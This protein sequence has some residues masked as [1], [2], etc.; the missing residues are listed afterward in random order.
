MPATVN[1][2]VLRLL[3][4]EAPL[5]FSHYFERMM[6]LP[7]VWKADT[8]PGWEGASQVILTAVAEW[9]SQEIRAVQAP[10][11]SGVWMW[12]LPHTQAQNSHRHPTGARWAW[13]KTGCRFSFSAE[14]L[15]WLGGRVHFLL[16]NCLFISFAH[17]CLPI[18]RSGLY[19]KDVNF[20]L[21]KARISSPV[22]LWSFSPWDGGFYPR[23]CFMCLKW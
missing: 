1:S 6:S 8:G 9:L 22:C 14:C 20:L 3:A 7:F 13:M 15:L 23:K 18:C 11:A 21:Q 19:I 16:Q 17:F 5:A 12:Q 4:P 10:P 2:S